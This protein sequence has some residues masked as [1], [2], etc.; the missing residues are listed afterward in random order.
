MSRSDYGRI[1]EAILHLA[2]NYKD[3]PGLGE[4]ARRANLSE[5]HFQRLFKT[6][7]GVSPKR[8]GQFLTAGF[9][10]QLLRDSRP[11]LEAAFE[12]GL[13]GGG[14]LHDLTVNV[15]A[16]TPGQVA[17]Q[18]EGLDLVW[19]VG[20][21][22]FG[23][24]FLA[25]TPRGIC[26]LAFLGPEGAQAPLE[27]LE[28]DWPRARIR[29]DRAAAGETVDRIFAATGPQPDR[30]LSLLV[31][32]T[33]LQLQVWEALLMVPWGTVVSYQDLAA[34]IGRPRA[35]RAVASAVAKN[36]VAF[37]IP[38]HRVIRSSGALGGYQWGPERK[39]ALLGWE[40]ARSGTGR[41]ASAGVA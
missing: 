28:N 36:P 15:F 4:L 11:V 19:G 16:M 5:F 29:E 39:R 6:W 31:K 34:G 7:A 1:E 12:A 9:V 18:G 24:V 40:A 33:N 8:F 38:C 30:P 20:P 14:R 22:P 17:A 3:Q 37:A 13:S 32:G 26:R 21:S 10:R 35:V 2:A 23:P 27:K 41:L 25:Q